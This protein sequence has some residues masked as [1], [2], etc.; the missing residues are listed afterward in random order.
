LNLGTL[1]TKPFITNSKFLTVNA[2][3]KGECR[4]RLLNAKRE[5]LDAFGWVELKGDSIE[6]TIEWSKKL[7]SMSGKAVCLEFQ[8]KNTQLFG[9]NLN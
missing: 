8:L 3:V 2:N 1:I 5:P 6:H 7:N 9:F 4:V